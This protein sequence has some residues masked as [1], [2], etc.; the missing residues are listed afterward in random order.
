MA[1]TQISKIQVRYGLSQDIGALDGGEFGWAIDTQKLYIGNGR[2][3]EGAPVGG[4]TEVL[5]RAMV[6]QDMAAVLGFYTYAG[7]LGGYIVDTGLDAQTPVVRNYQDKFDD[8]F[9]VKDFG[10]VG[11]GTIDDT[12]ALQQ[13]LDEIYGRNQG[14]SPIRTRRKVHFPAGTYLISAELKIPPY[15]TLVGDG[16]ENVRI[17]Q[18]GAVTCVARLTTNLG[19]YPDDED[20]LAPFDYA[21]SVNI[22]GMTFET[23]G[24]TDVFQIDSATQCNFTSV[25]F[26]G[27]LTYPDGGIDSVGVRIF[28]STDVTN[29]INFCDCEFN[30]TTYGAEISAIN[31]HAVEDII[32][33]GC[34]FSNLYHGVHTSNNGKAPTGIKIRDSRFA[35]IGNYGIYG[36]TG[37]SGIVS[38]SNTFDEVGND[39]GG[40][41]VCPVIMFQAD[42]NFS[43]GDA[44]T[45]TIVQSQSVE[46]VN[47]EGFA[48]LSTAIDDA[49]KLG[50][51]YLVP[52]QQVIL[53]DNN[54]TIT[55]IP[56]LKSG[57]IDYTI[58]RNTMART[59][60]IKFASD[61]NANISFDDEYT[62]TGDTEVTLEVSLSSG[63]VIITM[64]STA[65][66]YTSY[67]TFDVKSLY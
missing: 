36:D 47:A 56:Y 6:S 29:M 43:I 28:A 67:I 8:F 7:S 52:G 65:M 11:N 58:V 40:S 61:T 39:Y 64:S 4:K 35:N 21:N 57:M 37:V 27:A 30:G 17:V 15:A 48:V 55:S 51:S 31:S 22:S 63:T 53:A 54:T 25:G 42:N 50:R 1:V 59:G 60:R 13:C 16:I 45:R 32:F 41:P 49:F 19:L 9:T 62:E 10:A 23:Q 24:I 3:S 12:L 20:N 2:V 33:S 14:T 34:V 44:F 38:A 18:S 66:G 46:R 5:T 26:V